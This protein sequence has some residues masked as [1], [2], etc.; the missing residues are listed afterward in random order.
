MANKHIRSDDEDEL[1][2]VVASTSAKRQRREEDDEHSDDEQDADASPR[3]RNGAGRRGGDEMDVDYQ[4]A[5]DEEADEL[6]E[7]EDEEEDVDAEQERLNLEEIARSMSGSA[8]RIAEAGVIRQVDLQNFMCHANTTVNF[9]PQVNF[10]VGVNGSGKS[11]VLTGIT[12]ALGGN[13]KA[14]NR[15]QKGGDLV[16]EG[17]PSA[18]VSVTL[19]NVGED[20]FQH[21]VY[22][23]QITI[24][25]TINKAGGG[26]Y[27][28]KN[29]EG[30]TVDTKKATLDQILDSFNIQV[31]NPMTVLT[32]DQSRQFL[33]S[34]S[35]KDKYTFFL[36]GTQLA[37]LTEEYEQI[38]SNT[39]TMDEALQRK[40]DL[41]PELKDD[42]RKAKERAKSAQLAWEQKQSLGPLRNQ[43]AWAC[44]DE[45]EKQVQFG[46]GKIDEQREE[47]VKIEQ[48]IEKVETI[49]AEHASSIADLQEAEAEA[50]EKVKQRLPRIEELKQIIKAN[51]D[52]TAKWKDAERTMNNTL[53]RLQATIEQFDEQIAEEERKL[54]R[55][56][57]AERKPL[58]DNIARANEQIADLAQRITE[59]RQKE[60]ELNEAGRAEGQRYEEIRERIASAEQ[61]ERDHVARIQHYRAS[62]NNSVVAYGDRMP[63]FMQAINSAKWNQK[64]IGPIGLSVKLNRQEYSRVLESFFGPTLNAFVVTNQQDARMLKAMHR[65]H[66]LDH[67]VPIL[68]QAYDNNFDFSHGEPDPS[69][70]TV[71]RACTITNDL[72]KQALIVSNH[73]ENCALVPTR[74]DGDVLLRTN[75]RNVAAAY[76]ADQFQVRINQGRSSSST[77]AAWKGA[78]RLL[79]DLTAMVQRVEE[80]RSRVLADL[81]QMQAEKEQIRQ[82]G[83]QIENDRRQAEAAAHAAQKQTVQLNHQIQNWDA[84]LKEE[85]PNN[86]AA[87]Q[88]NKRETEQERENMLAQY[89][90][91]LANFEKS[92]ASQGA[93]E[94]VEEKQ[95]IE[96]ELK[97]HEKILKKFRERVAKETSA[98]TT[99]KARF[100]KLASSRKTIQSTIEQYEAELDGV[101]KLRD[102]RVEQATS[103]CERP[104]VDKPKDRKRLEKEIDSIERALKQ[105]AKEHGA[106]LEEII[107]DLEKKKQKAHEAVKSTNE[108]ASLVKDRTLRSFDR[109]AEALGAAYDAR[110]MRWTDFRTHIAARARTMFQHHLTQRG[111]TGKLKFNHE[112][113]TLEILIQTEADAGSKKAK[114]K[115]TKSLSGGEKSFSTIC[116]LL[117]MWESVGCPLRCLDE[118]DVFMDAV[119]RRIAMKMMVDTAAQADQTQF[120]LITP[121]DMGSLSSFGD[122]V[123]IVKLADPSRASGALAHGR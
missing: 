86:I 67:N 57:E 3:A 49:L 121:Q 120:I 26:A 18:R 27:K 13:A 96:E 61:T 4:A 109:L 122:E 100:N 12:M 91:G 66:G 104:Q 103:I 89:N 115:D 37:Q 64:P 8:R 21:H 48:D 53:A 24:E 75:P 35:A 112:K 95:A 20:A 33:A 83:T 70:L 90:A 77:M 114:Q 58:R 51:R 69:I 118:F 105:Q 111:F 74:P 101:K 78:P 29:A 23:D 76:S 31:D 46:A 36:R 28:I 50:S 87:L 45:V 99:A 2:D 30:K 72:V 119:N 15:G 1:E 84:K 34:A 71:L 110:L 88:E 11:A 108:I 6:D 82:R 123:K 40:R 59:A 54:S 73:I 107:D 62:Q 81:Q 9:G 97:G 41:V 47:L 56:I 85:Q 19:A 93:A 14:T 80:D 106:T 102:E 94:A 16:M 65:Q 5:S 22:G 17:K 98:E 117:T 68:T 32:Q 116:L 63:R 92:P 38:R 52:R 10:L 113:C 39:E 55:D 43:L 7:D 44:V 60:A 42:Y 79:K 25:R